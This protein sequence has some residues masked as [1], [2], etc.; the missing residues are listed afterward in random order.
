MIPTLWEQH[1]F[2]L[3]SFM[4]S[5][6]S[7]VKGVVHNGNSDKPVSGAEVTIIAGGTGKA[8]TTTLLGEY[9]RILPP[10]NYTVLIN[11]QLNNFGE[12]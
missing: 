5:I 10:G 1:R 2:S 4:E 6:H 3:L 9:W 7:G 8:M 12:F 11:V